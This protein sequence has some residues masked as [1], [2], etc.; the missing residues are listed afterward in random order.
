LSLGVAA[1][2]K[3]SF[4]EYNL[5]AG[6]RVLAVRAE[7]PTLRPGDVAT[8]DAL[9]HAPNEAVSYEWSWCPF[10]H[11]A[12]GGCDCAMDEASLQARLAELGLPTDGVS[13]SLGTDAT[14]TLQYTLPPELLVAL[15]ADVGDLPDLVAP[16]DCSD[17]FPMSV[18]LVVRAGDAEIRAF[19]TVRL[20]IDATTPVNG[21]PTLAGVSYGEK[22]TSKSSALAVA[23]DDAPALAVGKTYDLFA[24]VPET[25]AE[26][27]AS[28]FGAP[29]ET[30]EVLT[31]TWFIGAG[32]TQSMRTSYIDG[33][34][35]FE[36]LT[37]NEWTM[38]RIDEVESDGADL[39][40]VLHD[41]RGGVT[42]LTRR[43][44][45]A[46]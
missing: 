40:L 30:R 1:G 41:E 14:A 7:P 16:P 26:P 22:P 23:V 8:L 42:W 12:D 34:L 20:A 3:S 29:G 36:E 18:G 11:G 35:G 5:V 10:R 39:I 37:H 24:E 46:Q 44:T 31:M 45:I 25:S 32:S 6:P 15:C 38:P 4:D 2:C 28:A 13:Y 33:E 17:G 43:F 9:V 27:I 21:N 19:K